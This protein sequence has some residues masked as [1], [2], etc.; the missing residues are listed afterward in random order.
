[1]KKNFFKSV[2]AL[3]C[4][5]V[6]TTSFVACGSD[7]D[8]KT[9]SNDNTR[10]KVGMIFD[11]QITDDMLKYCDIEISAN[12]GAGLSDK[13]T[14]TASDVK[15]GFF[16]AKLS[17]S[18]PANF[19]LTR[20]VKMKS[21]VDLTGV[22]TIKF[23]RGY[24]YTVGYYNAAGQYLEKDGKLVSLLNLTPTSTSV[25]KFI[26]CVNEGY[27]DKTITIAFDKNGNEVE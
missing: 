18:L 9:P 25:D 24:Q 12:N 21:N 13:K 5:C 17:A 8:D 2:F 19:T 4:A 15:D 26:Q 23:V 10:A 27:L 6:M 1:M 11:F 16:T 3:M 20:T 7:D 14:V 22:E